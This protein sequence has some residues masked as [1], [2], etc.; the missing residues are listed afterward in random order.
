MTIASEIEADTRNTVKTVGFKFITFTLA[1]VQLLF[2]R[3]RAEL[4]LS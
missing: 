1:R 2:K 4:K 3:R